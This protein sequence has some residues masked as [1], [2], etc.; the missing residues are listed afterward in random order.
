MTRRDNPGLKEVPG[1]GKLGDIK[2]RHRHTEAQCR[3][4]YTL[5]K[6]PE[7]QTGKDPVCS[8]D[9]R[10]AEP[11]TAGREKDRLLLREQAE[12]KWDDQAEDR[13]HAALVLV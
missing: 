1:V 12:G 2:T 7:R 3:A 9:G 5:S 10:G 8:R 11:G 13:C 6:G 4:C